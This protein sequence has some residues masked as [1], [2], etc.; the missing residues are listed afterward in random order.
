MR[1]SKSFLC[2]FVSI[3]SILQVSAKEYKD[4]QDY[5][6]QTGKDE[7]SRKDWLTEDRQNNTL[8]WQGA[9]TYNFAYAGGDKEFANAGQYSDFMFWL[10]TTFEKNGYQI[11]MPLILTEYFFRLEEMA[12]STLAGEERNTY[13]KNIAKLIFTSTYQD[14]QIAYNG[15][16][17]KGEEASKW[18]K[19]LLAKIE[20]EI[21]QP[22]YDRMATV[23][24]EKV[25]A[26]FKRDGLLERKL[27]PAE[28]TW[29]TGDLRK[30]DDRIKYF[31]ET[32]LAYVNGERHTRDE[33]KR[34][35]T[36]IKDAKKAKKE[37]VSKAKKPKKV[38]KIKAN[39]ADKK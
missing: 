35:N 19:A 15:E 2:L 8:Q 14:L 26:W 11:I 37:K 29:T 22:Y 17:L 31:G 9:C 25:S 16:T 32:Y 21:T 30:A 6:I 24:L 10:K 33:V 20:K 34:T 1:V 5:K 39:K 4:K 27:Y 23:T 12:T 7:I 38:K 3:L 36:K 28:L 18:D 13:G